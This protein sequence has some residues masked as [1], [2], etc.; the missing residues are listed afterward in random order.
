VAEVEHDCQKF[1]K[2]CESL[3]EGAWLKA[4]Y[5]PWHHGTERFYHMVKL[6]IPM[7][8]KHSL[9]FQVKRKKHRHKPLNSA[10]S[11]K[12]LEKLAKE[13]SWQGK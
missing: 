3:R 10:I 8:H 13:E 9:G 7:S 5:M 4:V 11:A 12:S 2:S 1:R 6:P